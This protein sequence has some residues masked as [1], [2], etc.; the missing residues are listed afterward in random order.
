[1]CVCVCVCVCVGVERGGVG[2]S[3]MSLISLGGVSV[4]LKSKII[5]YFLCLMFFRPR[6]LVQSL[7]MAAMGFPPNTC[8]GTRSSLLE[9]LGKTRL[10]IL[11]GMHQICTF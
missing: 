5:S 10:V 8:T 9:E 7:Q 2:D 1:M 6:T 3:C 11:S 4:Y